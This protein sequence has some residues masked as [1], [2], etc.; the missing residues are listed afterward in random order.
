MRTRASLRVL[1]PALLAAL[2]A[3]R[4]AATWT[5]DEARRG[6]GDGCDC[7]C[8]ER[9]P[10]CGQ[11]DAPLLDRCHEKDGTVVEPVSKDW[12]CTAE[13]ECASPV[14]DCAAIHRKDG[15]GMLP[16]GDCYDGHVSSSA[17]GACR[18]QGGVHFAETETD[19]LDELQ[20][21]FGK[22]EDWGDRI[23]NHEEKHFI[24]DVDGDGGFTFQTDTLALDIALNDLDGDDLM[25]LF[26]DFKEFAD[27]DGDGDLDVLCVNILNL[28]HGTIEYYRNDD[29][30]GWGLREVKAVAFVDLDKDPDGDLDLIIYGV[31][32]EKGVSPTRVLENRD[33]VF[34]QVEDDDDPFSDLKGLEEI[35]MCLRLD[36]DLTVAKN[37]ETILKV[38]NCINHSS[39]LEYSASQLEDLIRSNNLRQEWHNFLSHC[40]ELQDTSISEWDFSI[41]VSDMHKYHFYNETDVQDVGFARF[42]PNKLHALFDFQPCQPQVFVRNT[43]V[44]SRFGAF[45]PASLD[46]NWPD[47]TQAYALMD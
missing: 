13:N 44:N 46:L 16:C 39:D 29:L 9:D 22:T 20:R 10:D 26:P 19:M 8:G 21:P 18:L 17:Q 28:T 35:K 3:A 31:P 23:E 42:A 38:V 45:E 30:R 47:E 2:L 7:G 37:R 36:R 6:S 34:E 5:C 41:L 27:F 12:T 24:T 25:D 14:P 43:N 32:A 4:S 33:G 40:E 15:D 11:D 1:A